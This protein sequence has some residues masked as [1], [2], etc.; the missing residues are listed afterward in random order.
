MTIARL[1]KNNTRATRKHL[2]EYLADESVHA[3]LNAASNIFHE[4]ELH[5]RRPGK[6]PLLK[7][8]YLKPRLKLA[9]EHI[10]ET[11]FAV[12]WNEER[13]VPPE[14]CEVCLDKKKGEASSP[15]DY[16]GAWLWI[17]N[18]MWLFFYVSCRNASPYRRNF[19]K[20]K[21]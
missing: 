17:D 11:G 18:V 4:T 14:W 19:E 10:L 5:E 16:S 13:V 6:T 7:E 20:G 1:V 15:T 8:V 3:S 9:R 12:T 2:Q 21:L